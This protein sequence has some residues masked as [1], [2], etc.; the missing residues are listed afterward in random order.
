MLLV[1]NKIIAVLCLLGSG[2]SFACT[3]SENFDIYFSRNSASVPSE[4][5]IRLAS[6]VIDKKIAYANHKTKEVTL[7]SGHAEEGERRPQEL[8]R[9]RLEAGKALLEQFRFLRGDVKTSVR[10]YMRQGVDNGRRVEI[11][12]E[13]DCPNKCCTGE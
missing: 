7:V 6:W 12:F 8:A 10:V 1:L 11:S 13:P 3:A 9:L 4:E 5:I 2:S